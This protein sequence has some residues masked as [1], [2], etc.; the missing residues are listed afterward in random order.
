MSAA[1]VLYFLKN[2]AELQVKLL[3]LGQFRECVTYAKDIVSLGTAGFVMQL[4]N[5][6]VSICC[7]SVLSRTGGDVYVS[8]MTIVSSVRQIVETPIWSIAEGASSITSRPLLFLGNA[9]QSRILSRPA[10][11]LTQRSRPYARP[12]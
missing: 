4:T 1:F 8:V 11:M 7:N 3:S 6:L 2:K 10:K 5:S 12:P 9:M